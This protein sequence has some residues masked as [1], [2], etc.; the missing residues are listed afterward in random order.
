MKPTLNGLQSAIDTGAVPVPTAVEAVERMILVE[1]LAELS[2]AGLSAREAKTKVR[3]DAGSLVGEPED[4]VGVDPSVNVLGTTGEFVIEGVLSLLS[5]ASTV[6]EYVVKLGSSHPV[7][8]KLLDLAGK[9]ADRIDDILGDLGAAESLMG[10]LIDDIW[11]NDLKSDLLNGEYETADGFYDDISGAIDGREETISD[12][13]MSEYESGKGQAN[14][15]DNTLERVDF[16]LSVEDGGPTFSGGAAKDG[17]LQDASAAATTGR[18]NIAAVITDAQEKLENNEWVAILLNIIELVIILSAVLVA[19]S[20]GASAPIG[21]AISLIFGLPA[22]VLVLIGIKRG[23]DA[24][25]EVLN[26]CD[27]AAR[28]I[29]DG[30]SEASL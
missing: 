4:S 20:G 15:L 6:S 17:P 11:Q 7:A 30:N 12:H 2:L 1:D 28:A 18:T 14:A 3:E 19:P 25:D 23:L 21:A 13:M 26:I 10:P 29:V 24:G 16:E 9:A 27:E 8:G 5:L 22:L